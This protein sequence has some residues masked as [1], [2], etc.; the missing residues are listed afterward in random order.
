ML[1]VLA[2]ALVVAAALGAAGVVLAVQ[3]LTMHRVAI[4][5]NVRR[6][7][8]RTLPARL[9][10]PLRRFAD[11]VRERVPA[12]GLL[13]LRL[14]AGLLAVSALGVLFGALLEDVTAGEG[15]ALIDHPVARFVA[16]HRT[17]RLTAVMKGVSWVGGPAG[18]AVFALVCAGVV[19]VMRRNWSAVIVVTAGTGGIAAINAVLKALIGRSRPPLAQAVDTAAGYA[20]PSGHAASAT[21]TL[22]VLA[23]VAMHRLRSTAARSAAWAASAAGAA[24]VSMS[25]VYLGVH[26]LSDVLGGMLVGALWAT[27]VVTAWSA[28]RGSAERRGR[29]RAHAAR[30]P[31]SP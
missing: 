25:R 19:S 29:G 14:T 21:A 24:L 15:I 1:V 2:A 30:V 26:W 17:S 5:V 20:F 4:A 31:Q 7:A 10:L 23:Y 27:V 28:Y 6:A 12:G 9:P 16:A 13:G 8:Y 11:L 3:W 18:I 22:A